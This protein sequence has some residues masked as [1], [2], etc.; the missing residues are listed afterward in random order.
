M[1]RWTKSVCAEPVGAAANTS[2]NSYSLK[3]FF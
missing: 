2:A 3:F 1:E